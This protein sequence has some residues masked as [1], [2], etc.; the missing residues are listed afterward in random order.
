MN[1]RSIKVMAIIS[2]ILQT[3]AAVAGFGIVVFQKTLV[4]AFMRIPTDSK[5]MVF[6]VTL[7]FV[8]VQLIIYIA[9]YSIS[10]KEGDRVTVIILIVLSIILAV[11]SVFG[12]VLGSFIYS[13]KGAEAV[14]VYSSVTS[15]MSYI[16]TLFVIPA[17]ALFY[18]ACGRYTSK[19]E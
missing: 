15:I 18:I 7:L 14:A 3:V 12:N 6:P 13:R 17:E 4:R 9:F 8:V 2:V 5:I 10:Q 16:N 1:R 11:M 19:P